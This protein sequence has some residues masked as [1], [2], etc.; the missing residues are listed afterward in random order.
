[1]WLRTVSTLRCNS[2]AI[3]SVEPAEATPSTLAVRLCLESKSSVE[4]QKAPFLAD[5][6]AFSLS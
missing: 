6:G 5:S 4:T 1:M 3:C 2:A